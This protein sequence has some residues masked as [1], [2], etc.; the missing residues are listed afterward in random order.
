MKLGKIKD[1]EIKIHYSTLIIIALVGFYAANFFSQT[2]EEPV[3]ITILIIVGI[4]NG[5]I[6]LFSIFAHELMHSLMAQHYNLNV[7]EI[8]FHMFG[9]VSRIEEEPKTPRSEMFIA[10]V[11]PLTSLIIGTILLMAINIQLIFS[12]T[13]PSPII[14]TTLLYSGFSNLALGIFNLL[15]AFPMDGGRILRAYLWKK[16]EN[17][18]AATKTAS[19][20]GKIISY[21]LIAYGFIQIFLFGVIGGLWLIVIGWFLNSTSKNAYTQT[22][23]QVKLSKINTG[24]IFDSLENKISTNSTISDAIRDYFIKYKETYFP[25]ADDNGKVIG[26]IDIEK[27]KNIPRNSRKEHKVGDYMKEISKFPIVDDDSSAKEAFNKLNFMKEKP[28]VVVVKNKETNEVKG[29]IGK[30]EILGALKISKLFF[31][32]I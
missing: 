3:S 23:Y 16:K 1:I 29:F 17:L 13:S 14:F 18:L 27:I 31:E 26:I 24:E 4:V 28:R 30:N 21:G 10:A 8:E 7:S 6:M 20:V 5:L 2:V 25:V 32:E 22:K 9:G 11:G 15:P 12:N 19:K